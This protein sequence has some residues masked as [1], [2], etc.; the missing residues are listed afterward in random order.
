M[1]EINL[2]PDIKQELIRAKRI[3]TLIISGA[4]VVGLAAIGIVILLAVYLFGIQTVRSALADSSITSKSKQ[5]SN[6]ADLG[7]M[8]TIQHQL[9]QLTELHD[10]KN[11]DSRFFDLLAAINP[12]PPNQVTFSLAQIDSDEGTIELEG[13]APNGY[14]AADV[15]KKTILGTSFSYSDGGTTKTVPLT[16]DVAVP[17]LSYG[18][19]S[20]GNMVLRFTM[21]FVYNN[22]LFARS[23]ENAHIIRPDRQD[24][25][26][27]FLHLPVSLFGNSTVDQKEGN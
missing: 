15:L 22:A 23:S 8:L 21:S 20:T 11:I 14:A 24:A 6:V 10:Q 3:R 9:S 13:Q 17:Q 4:I 19:D 2:V 12:S 7:D 1:I 25:T 5:L 26:D 27:S 18:Q 16:D